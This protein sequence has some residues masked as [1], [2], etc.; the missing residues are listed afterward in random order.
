MYKIISKIDEII[1][2][3]SELMYYRKVSK[4]NRV[5]ELSHFIRNKLNDIVDEIKEIDDI[6]LKSLFMD[7]AELNNVSER[8]FQNII[9]EIKEYILSNYEIDLTLYCKEN[10]EQLYKKD[11]VLYKQVVDNNIQV[12]NR[13]RKYN[14]E[15]NKVCDISVS[16]EIEDETRINIC[17]FGNPWQEALIYAAATDDKTE[18]CIV[19]GFGLGYHIQEMSKMYPEME[20][21][22]LENDIEQIR[23]AINYRNISDIMSN[24]N[25]HI[26]FCQDVS[27]YAKYFEKMAN[28]NDSENMECKMWMPSVKV[29]ENKELRELLERY[30]VSF[31]SM[32]YFK[33]ILEDNFKKNQLLNDD[34]ICKTKQNIE[35]KDVIL[36][37]A[38]PSL[39]LEMENLKKILISKKRDNICVIC[40][41]KIC[42][43]IIKEGIKPNYIIVTDAKESTRWQTSGVEESGIPLIYLSTAASNLTKEYKGKRYIAYQKGFKE[44]EKAAMEM[45]LPL[46]ETGGSVATFAIDLVIRFECK[47]LVCVGLDMGYMDEKT[48][49]GCIGG[50]ITDKS[51]LKEIDGVDGKKVYT[52]I[53]LDIYRKWIEERIANGNNIEII[54]ASHGAKILGMK[55]QELSNVYSMKKF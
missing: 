29:I 12:N 41:G 7:N 10:L 31:F 40:V 9:C 13:K 24:K 38:G 20:M 1:R 33:N 8:K 2:A 18:K 54:N 19:F 44:A 30:K 55:E 49:A 22:V 25:V 53:S 35:G 42:R 6:N 48:H 11:I 32:G 34:N 4:C 16:I 51:R 27:D 45:G 23:T 39:D 47:R 50:K 37:A 17:S 28:I 52:N 26:F 46:F 43:R 15:L 14:I 3:S 21:F 36:I 5:E